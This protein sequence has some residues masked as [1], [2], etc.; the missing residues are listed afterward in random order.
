MNGLRGWPPINSKFTCIHMVCCLFSW[1]PSHQQGTDRW[2][3]WGAALSLQGVDDGIVLMSVP[4]GR[5]CDS[6]AEWGTMLPTCILDVSVLEQCHLYG[7]G[8]FHHAGFQC[9]FLVYCFKSILYSSDTLSIYQGRHL[10]SIVLLPF[11]KS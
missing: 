7:P 11:I 1:E 6:H 8:G 10:D 9:G 5:A 2:C 3:L 4:R